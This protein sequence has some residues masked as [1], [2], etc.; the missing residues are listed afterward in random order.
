MTY[1]EVLIVFVLRF[2][3][4]VVVVLVLFF[5]GGWVFLGVRF[6]LHLFEAVGISS[7]KIRSE[8]SCL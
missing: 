4:V 2:G 7:I 5:E 6:F 8:K 1:E 3:V